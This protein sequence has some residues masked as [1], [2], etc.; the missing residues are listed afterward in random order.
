MKDARHPLLSALSHCLQESRGF[1]YGAAIVGTVISAS[2]ANTPSWGTS[3]VSAGF[4]MSSSSGGG[5]TLRL[6]WSSGLM[7]AP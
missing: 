5:G 3:G 2:T 7:H 4:W 6:N 1:F